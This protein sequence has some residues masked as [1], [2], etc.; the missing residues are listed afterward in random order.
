VPA[1]A[2]HEPASSGAGLTQ[3]L[4]GVSLTII[5]AYGVEGLS[6]CALATRLG[7]RAH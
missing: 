6:M 3:H 7:V 5:D 2:Y 1:A 4:G